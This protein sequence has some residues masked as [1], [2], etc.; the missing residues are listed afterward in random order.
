ML[1]NYCDTCAKEQNL[2]IRNGTK[3]ILPHGNCSICNALAVLHPGTWPE[4]IVERDSIV[5]GTM[6]TERE[7]QKKFNLVRE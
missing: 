6:R 4:K 3:E 1:A 2:P 7:S 5:G